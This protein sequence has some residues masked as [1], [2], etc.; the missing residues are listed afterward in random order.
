MTLS[1]H[2]KHC[3]SRLTMTCLLTT[4]LFATALP[5]LA[6]PT[7][8]SLRPSPELAFTVPGQ[9]ERL[10]SQYRGQVVALE[11]IVTTCPHCQAASKVM[12][13]LQQRY[14]K[15]GLQ[16]LAVAIDPDADGRVANFALVN[17]VGFPVGW[18]TLER[19]MTYMGFTQ[20]PVVPQLVLID[21]DGNIRYQT[22]REGDADSMKEEVIAQ[23]M[24]ELL[25]QKPSCGR[26][27]RADTKKAASLA[28][29]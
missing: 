15:R 29:R 7:P 10:L 1:F 11:F 20:R 17:Q 4:A 6:V 2:N 25:A 3:T 18:T 21:R 23:R 28:G 12:T 22:P 19:M 27:S 13:G 8:P 9:G 5:G 14:G 24:E 16:A 26:R